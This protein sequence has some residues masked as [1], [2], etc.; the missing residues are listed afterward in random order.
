M[1]EPEKNFGLSTKESLEV[2]WNEISDTVKQKKNASTSSYLQRIWLAVFHDDSPIHWFPVLLSLL[3]VICLFVIDECC[4]AV[5][6]LLLLILTLIVVVREQRLKEQEIFTK[7]KYVL[8]KSSLKLSPLPSSFSR[9][10]LPEDIRHSLTLSDSW[11]PENYPNVCSPVS[12]CVTLQCTYRDG[13]IRNLPWALLVKGD[14]IV[15]RPGQTAPGPCHELNGTRVF[16]SGETYSQKTSVNPPKRP[17]ARIPLPNLICVMDTTP[18]LENLVVAIDQFLLKPRTIHNRQRHFLVTICVQQWGTVIALIVTLI[19]GFLNSTEFVFSHHRDRHD[20]EDLFLLNSVSVLVPLLPLLFPVLWISLNLWGTAKLETLTGIARPFDENAETESHKSFHEDLDTPVDVDWD[21]MRLPFRTNMGNFLGLIQGS[22]HL[23]GRSAN[24][25][26]VLGSITALTCV[27]K[28]GIL[29]WPNPTAEKIFFLRDS[30][31]DAEDERDL[32][33][34]ECESEPESKNGPT[35]PKQST[36]AEVLDLTHDQHSPFR[37]EFDDH[38]WKSHINSLK[39][40]GE[41]KFRK[42]R[43]KLGFVFTF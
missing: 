38:T 24:V 9:S 43:R 32:S 27:D 36:V 40:L 3:S 25:V 35:T 37:M 5:I 28:K 39:P 12:P 22:G 20:W 18:F 13:E 1:T 34:S 6:I 19:S 23:L 29:S 26:Q 15:M 2:L 33:T 42:R 14:C 11:T 10:F 17:S 21:N 30:D 41:L 7:V 4:P 31:Q 16:T 8:G